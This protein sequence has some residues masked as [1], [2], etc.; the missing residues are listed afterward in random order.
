MGGGCG[1]GMCSGAAAM[2]KMMGGGCGD[3]MCSA[4]KV[5]GGSANLDL[6]PKDS[7]YKYNSNIG[8]DPAN[9]SAVVGARFAGD[10]SRTS[11]GKR[12]RRQKKMRGGS[13]FLSGIYSQI[14]NAGSGMGPFTSFGTV[15]GTAGQTAV[16]SGVGG[17]VNS[18][19]TSQ[20]VVTDKYGF[21]NPPLA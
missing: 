4:G 21:T 15:N 18:S 17:V 6:I 19:V 12:R 9:P 7:F 16:A 14:Q 11:G 20:P 10:Y 3:G 13:N 8:G 5:M 1:E 2:P